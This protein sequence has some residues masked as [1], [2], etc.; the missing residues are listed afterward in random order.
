MAGVFQALKG[1]MKLPDPVRDIRLRYVAKFPVPQSTPGAIDE[2]ARQ[3]SI[4]FAEQVLFETQDARYGVKR[5]DPGRP[6]CKDCLARNDAGGLITWDL[7]EA[8]G[9]G[10][11]TLIN[12]PDSLDI[13]DQVFVPVLPVNHLGS[14]Q[15][16][17]P[18]PVPGHALADYF[19]TRTMIRRLYREELN[20]DVIADPDALVNWIYHWREHG[21]DEAWIRARIRES[22]E[23]QDNH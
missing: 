6:I 5:A 12:D 14:S 21:R 19:T 22:D 7:L 20:R 2:L 10:S 4:H 11:P 13:P 8:T 23:W 15:T 1:P 3:W 16:P 9:T 17:V 18:V